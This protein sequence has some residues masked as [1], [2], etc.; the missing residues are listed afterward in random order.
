MYNSS[1]VLLKGIKAKFMSMML[2]TPEPTFGFAIQNE[3]SK[4]NKEIYW[5]P[6]SLP[7]IKEWIVNIGFSSVQDD[8]FEVL[9]KDWEDGLRVKRNTLEDSEIESSINMWVKS[10][11]DQYKDFPDELG[12]KI[13]SD[14]AAIWDGTALFSNTRANIDTASNTIDNLYSGTLSTAYTTTTFAADFEGALNDIKGFKDKSNRSFNKRMK[15]VVFVPTHLYPI[16]KKILGDYQT[17]IDAGTAA[18]VTNIYANQAE[19]IENWEQGSSDNDWYII[20]KNA[21]IKPF[22]I[23]SRKGVEWNMDDNKKVKFIDYW[24]T[25]R[26]GYSGLNPFS[27]IKIDN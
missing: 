1:K 2:T 5:M 8:Y 19:I 13:L 26:M 9:N 11:A 18:Q 25:F 3:T 6:H 12:Q 20:N 22:L 23:Q 15:P 27:I 16:A 24:F 17:Y 14:N 4:S 21:P 10:M 7:A